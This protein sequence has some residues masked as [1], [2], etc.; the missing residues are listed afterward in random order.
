[1]KADSPSLVVASSSLVRARML[2]DAGIR[3]E[4]APS[5]VDEAA[6][7][8][9]DS[10]P[11]QMAQGLAAAK[12]V[13]VSRDWDGLVIGADQTLDLDGGRLDKPLDLADARRQLLLMRGKT[14]WLHAAAAVAHG[15][16][17]VWRTIDSAR[18]TVRSF[19][20]DY[21]DDYLAR[22]GDAILGCVGCYRLE[23]EGVQLFDCIE[24]DYF[25]VLGLP[26]SPLLG[27]L[28]EEGVLQS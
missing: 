8:S 24:G 3:I 23:G 14:H 25:T 19:S 7:K 15:G 27:F 9:A 11:V 10:D 17:V 22:E 5:N 26:L 28:R 13:A 4:I 12:A 20:D 16:E 2:R 21:L 1:M 6:F 18:L